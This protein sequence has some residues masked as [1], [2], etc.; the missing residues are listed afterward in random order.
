[1]KKTKKTTTIVRP[2]ESLTLHKVLPT[3]AKV[4]SSLDYLLD[5][6]IISQLKEEG[7]VFPVC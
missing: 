5:M 6:P 4:K 2:D 7:S 3:L 1:M